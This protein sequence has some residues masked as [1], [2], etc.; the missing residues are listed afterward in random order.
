MNSKTG[1]TRS[2][3]NKTYLVVGGTKTVM[4]EMSLFN[5]GDDAYQSAL[6]MRLP[7]GIYFIKVLD[8]QEQINCAVTDEENQLTRLDC[9]IGHLYVD[10]FSRQQFSFLLDTTSLSS[11]E[12]VI[13]NVT[14]SCQNEVD[15]SSLWN[16]EAVFTIPA[17][18]EVN[19]NVAGYVSPISLVYGPPE[20]ERNLCVQET[21]EYT[22][23]VI[24]A[25]PSLVS[26][27][28]FQIMIPNIFAPR[29]FKLFHILDVKYCFEDDETCLHVDC[30]FGDMES[31]SEATVE[32]KLE[33]NHALLELVSKGRCVI[34]TIHNDSESSSRSSSQSNPKKSRLKAVKPIKDV[35]RS[36]SGTFL[37]MV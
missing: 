11:A 25:G 22:F 10:S 20:D 9:N 4:I 34:T 1:E 5:A 33:T 17:R 35:E 24:N 12:D 21:V 19:V 2:S 15:E 26:N 13:I 36:S 18:Y 7:K 30:T 3:E 8:Q 37:D 14:V 23:N 6:H 28:T 29:D 32:V 31:D 16:N 27:T